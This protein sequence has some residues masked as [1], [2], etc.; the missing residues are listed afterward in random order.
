M[1]SVFSLAGVKEETGFEDDVLTQVYINNF[2][3]M[4]ERDIYMVQIYT[5]V[6][7]I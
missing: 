3:H 6:S 2:M 4:P 7:K 1:F 5:H